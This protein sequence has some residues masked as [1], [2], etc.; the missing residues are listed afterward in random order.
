[1]IHLCSNYL[2]EPNRSCF[3]T[4][5][6]GGDIFFVIAFRWRIYLLLMLISYALSPVRGLL[7]K[8]A[9]VPLLKVAK[10]PGKDEICFIL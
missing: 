1:M 9:H 4:D 7:W 6:S 8:S 2:S 10:L 3:S 5:V